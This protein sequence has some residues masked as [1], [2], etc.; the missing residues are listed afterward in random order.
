MKRRAY[1]DMILRA[2]KAEDGQMLDLIAA[3][4]ADAE[5]TKQLLV[6]KGYGQV[7]MPASAA[8]RMVPDNSKGCYARH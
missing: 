3:Q 2:A 7:S 1:R 8:A 5:Q 4:L 6:A